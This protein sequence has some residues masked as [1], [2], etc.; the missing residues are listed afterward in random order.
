MVKAV[1]LVV[2]V[3]VITEVRVIRVV[4][5]GPG[6]DRGSRLAMVVVLLYAVTI[7]SFVAYAA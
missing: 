2:V 5:G 6:V 4:V 3:V 1:E 7:C